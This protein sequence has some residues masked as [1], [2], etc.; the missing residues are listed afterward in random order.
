MACTLNVLIV[1]KISENVW[2]IMFE[3]PTPYGL[4]Y[5]PSTVHCIYATTKLDSCVLSI[6]Y[7]GLQATG[8]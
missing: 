4:L 8:S 1:P 5:F 7:W 2:M 3:L 6:E